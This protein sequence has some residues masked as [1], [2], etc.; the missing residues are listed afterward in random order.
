MEE[1]IW[2]YI[3]GQCTE[4][5]NIIV[6]TKLK[7]DQEF[8]AM[9]ELASDMDHLLSDGS[10][11][12][13]SA[14]FAHKLENSIIHH[15][16][17]HKKSSI[18][19]ILPIELI[20]G[21]I[22]IAVGVFIYALTGYSGNSQFIPDL[23]SIDQKIITMFNVVMIGFGLLAVLDYSLKSMMKKKTTFMFCL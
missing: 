3:D 5:E 16:L 4:E 13:M 1:L 11:V 14:P 12:A 7:S 17:T 21:L 6:Q 18:T 19:D 20:I 2:K 9:Y 15:V 23:P 22:V 10:E 8:F